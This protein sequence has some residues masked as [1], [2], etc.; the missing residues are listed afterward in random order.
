VSH[1]TGG[2]LVNFLARDAK[3]APR[4]TIVKTYDYTDERGDLLFQAVRYRPKDFKQRRPDGNGGWIWKLSDVRRVPYRL[5]EV[6]A[7]DPTET[8]YIFEGEED[9]DRAYESGLVAT[10]N[11]QGVGKWQDEY[12]SYLQGR[13]VVVVPDNDTDGHKHGEEVARSAYPLASSVKVLHL[14]DLGHKEDFRDWLDKHKGTVE[15]LIARAAGTP[16]WSPPSANGSVTALAIAPATVP[17]PRSRN[18][19]MG[20]AE[21][22]VSQ[23]GENVRY[24]YTWARWLVWSGSRWALDDSGM[25]HRLAK[26]T[27]KSIYVEAGAAETEEERKSLAAHARKSESANAIEAMLRLARPEVP[28]LPEDL[29]AHPYLLNTPNGTVNL[30][31]GE[32]REHRREDLLTKITGADYRPDTPAP[33]WE[34]FLERVLPSQDLRGFVQRASG[35]SATGDTSEQAMFINHGVGANGKSTFH[36]AIAAALGDYATRTPTDM[37]MA[38]RF[39]GVPNDVARLKGAR[40]VA[41][42]ETEEGRRLDEARIKDLTGQDTI[43]ARFMKG[44]WFDFTPTHK[45]HLSTNHKPEIRGTDNAI[46]RRIRLIPWSVTVPPAEQDKKL[47]ERL[48]AEL[49]GILSW[50]VNGCLQWNREGLRPPDEVRKATG[51]YRAEMDVLSAFLREECAVKEDESTPATQLYDAYREWCDETGEKAEK[52]RK[53]GERLKERGYDKRRITSGPDKGKYEYLGIILLRSKHGIG[54]PLEGGAPPLSGSNPA[55]S[56]GA[57][58]H[59]GG[60][61]EQSFTEPFTAENPRKSQGNSLDTIGSGEQ[62]ELHSD[63]SSSGNTL[64]GGTPKKGSLH[65]LHSPVEDLKELSALIHEEGEE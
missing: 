57:T 42:A 17:P 36:E 62:S 24:C 6:L 47:P 14:P 40:F 65:S 23:H 59:P 38:R 8:V 51:E 44:E 46:W 13:N 28:V 43:T 41:A 1:D 56:E 33:R 21:R 7:A 29:D 49:S 9:V 55:Q 61:G 32:T 52:Q 30:R 63:L 31:T 11:P 18:T 45:L 12:S 22:F 48:R 37:L 34:A 10:T 3:R 4:P 2:A 64:R 20:N 15:E 54:E 26:E 19:D 60:S 50:V 39:T 53:F 58:V 35:Y 5:P 25:V 16:P 27:V